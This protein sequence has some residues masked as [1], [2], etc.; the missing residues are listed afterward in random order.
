MLKINILYNP[1]YGLKARE[2]GKIIAIVVTN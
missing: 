2:E 1:K